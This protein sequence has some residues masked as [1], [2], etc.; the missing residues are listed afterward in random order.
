MVLYDL[1]VFYDFELCEFLMIQ[2]LLRY[3]ESYILWIKK[4]SVRVMNRD[5]HMIVELQEDIAT[6]EL[7]CPIPA[8]VLNEFG[9]YE[10]TELEW[11][12]EGG[13]LILRESL[14]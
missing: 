5:E 4:E 6:G 13:E 3:P 7:L 14:Q 11:I 2:T 1:K 12:M 10:G 9:W 8:T